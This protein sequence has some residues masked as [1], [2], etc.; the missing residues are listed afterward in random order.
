MDGFLSF[1]G[2]LFFWVRRVYIYLNL[3]YA[4]VENETRGI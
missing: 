1:V 3:T 2:V 4:K